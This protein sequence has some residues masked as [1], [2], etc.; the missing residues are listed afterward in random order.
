[1]KG[2]VLEPEWNLGRIESWAFCNDING[3]LT[4]VSGVSWGI[5]GLFLQAKQ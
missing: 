2:C 5:S 1:M 3:P 4:G